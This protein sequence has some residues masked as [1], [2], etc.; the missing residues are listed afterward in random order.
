[1]ATNCTY[2]W[3]TKFEA[4]SE[5]RRSAN[6]PAEWQLNSKILQSCLTD[7][8]FTPSIDLFASRLNKQFDKFV[9]VKPEPEA[10]AIDAWAIYA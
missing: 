9:S 10:F 4:D 3:Q 8:D 2:P 1:M 5:S 6:T 7:I